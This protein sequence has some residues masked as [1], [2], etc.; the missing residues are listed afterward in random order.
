MWVFKLCLI[1]N[2]NFIASVSWDRNIKVWNIKTGRCFLTLEEH[3]FSVKSVIYIPGTNLLVSGG[4]DNNIKVWNLFRR[5]PLGSYD[6][7]RDRV[8]CLL[9]IKNISLLASGSYDRTIKLTNIFNGCVIR[10]MNGHLKEI[11]SL[12]VKEDKN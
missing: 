11:I 3:V 12:L 9:W 10:V 8:E 7:H 6:L 1:E 2:S 5:K 4:N